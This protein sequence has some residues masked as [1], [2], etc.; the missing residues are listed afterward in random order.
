LRTR[1]GYIVRSNYLV[2]QCKRNLVQAIKAGDP[3][4]IAIATA[5][6]LAEDDV[7]L[8]DITHQYI[9]IAKKTIQSSLDELAV[10]NERIMLL[11]VR[12]WFDFATKQ[13]EHDLTT[14]YAKSVTS[15]LSDWDAI[16]AKGI[17]DIKPATL[18]I[19]QSSGNAAY[20]QLAIAGSFSVLNVEAVKAADKLCAK[21]VTN[22]TNKTKAGIRTYVSAGI[23]AGKSMSNVAR[24]LRRSGIVGLTK[25][26]TQSVL[27]YR[28]LLS[29]KEKYPK[30]TAADIDRKVQRYT[31][32][33]HRR[34][35][36]D[37]ARTETAAAQNVGYCQGLQDV[38]VT[39]SEFL[40]APTDACEDCLA[41]D[42][43]RYPIEEGK[44]IIP[45]HPK[46][47]CVMLP[48]VG[49]RTVSNVGDYDR[50]ELPATMLPCE[51]RKAAAKD[52]VP[53]GLP[54][55]KK[56][57]KLHS[58]QTS[59]ESLYD[60]YKLKY[61]THG[62]LSPSAKRFLKINAKRFEARSVKI[63]KPI[64]GVSTT[65]VTPAEVRT[66]PL[67]PKVPE[68]SLVQQKWE[69]S[70]TAEQ[71]K[72][73]KLFTKDYEGTDAVRLYQTGGHVP[74]EF[75]QMV[76]HFDD[77]I[78]LAP[79]Y[80][81]TV[82]R[83][84]GMFDEKQILAKYQSGSTVE[85]NAVASA[86]QKAKVTHEFLMMATEGDAFPVQLVIDVKSGINISRLSSWKSQKEIL[87]SKGSKYK[88]MK[89]PEWIVDNQ[90]V[91][92]GYYR[93]HLDEVGVKVPKIK[94]PLAV[95]KTKFI[96]AD[97]KVLHRY[98]TEEG[99]DAVSRAQRGLA[100]D[101]IYFEISTK[102]ALVLG[103]KI[104]AA[105]LKLSAKKGTTYRGLSFQTKAQQRKFLSQFDEGKTWQSKGLQS[106]TETKN[107][108]MQFLEE[109]A[110]GDPRNPANGVLLRFD[111]L[112]GRSLVKFSDNPRELEVLLMKGSKYKVVNIKGN[113]VFLKELKVPLPKIKPPKVLTQKEWETS[114]VGEKKE[115]FDFFTGDY[116]GYTD[117]RNYQLGKKVANV[118]ALKYGKLMDDAF[119]Q[120]PKYQGTVYRG[121][122]ITKHPEIN[123]YKKGSTVNFDATTSSSKLGRV[124]DEFMGYADDVDNI[125]VRFSIKT[126]SG[127]DIS[128]ISLYDDQAEVILSKGSRFKV[129]KEPEWIKSPAYKQGGYYQVN[130]QE[131]VTSKIKPPKLLPKPV[132][133]PAM[134]PHKPN[135]PNWKQQTAWEKN[136][137]KKEKA[138][139]KDWA[140]GGDDY[141]E[142]RYGLLN[143]KIP[144]S[145][146]Y[147]RYAGPMSSEQ[148]A[149]FVAD[150]KSAITK[151]PQYKGEV[152]R[153]LGFGSRKTVEKNFVKGKEIEFKFTQSGSRSKK[154][155]QT[156]LDNADDMNEVPVQLR[157][158]SKTG[159]Y[160]GDRS[161]YDPSLKMHQEEVLLHHGTKYK[162]KEVKFIK[163]TDFYRGGYYI[164][165]LVEL[166]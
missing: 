71:K 86:S 124:A 159:T 41:L 151:S 32:K 163:D 61:E 7:A 147:I 79:K 103:D 142:L 18:K 140:R 66:L 150:F 81:G 155:A 121:S 13:I 157:I 60:W 117:I 57:N 127:I 108:A 5:K 28:T 111:N 3:K 162:I 152:Y 125:P 133:R 1:Y 10:R 92:K 116:Y 141:F 129:T 161:L 85:Y 24:E 158:Q 14:K 102:E 49:E 76:E 2:L 138:R 110:A 42:G 114:I 77:A 47:R 115:A 56:Y 51:L 90:Y 19:M 145:V 99:F 55:W 58:E 11:A 27:N 73:I 17:D 21:L 35:M 64:P 36:N 130:L 70:L 113:E 23:K 88:V 9:A 48:V 40:I 82:Y 123:V 65:T 26:Q 165:D 83:G 101:P 78:A 30:L 153:S 25:P 37:I 38:G 68:P 20:R 29:D 126:K 44:G 50:S 146:D 107:Y 93:I 34:R 22:V 12:N 59:S 166:L 8:A 72:S 135:E 74:V 104:Q 39:E 106:T 84:M 148:R 139:I 143:R 156:F 149:K 105:A 164:V 98:T 33:T 131:I 144:D 100:L 69:A 67:K 109:T 118:R 112:T 137:T 96:T 16:N 75:R 89:K 45:V 120:A 154:A 53:T 15:E 136:L 132:E 6:V 160:L 97:E 52:C 128:K 80:K 95:P 122:G 62:K 94:P 87:L 4:K 119:A 46:C 91:T 63:I 31:D 54:A 134:K 43:Q